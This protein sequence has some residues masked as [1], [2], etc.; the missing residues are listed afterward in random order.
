MA[1]FG[2]I[3]ARTLATDVTTD[4]ADGLIVTTTG[5]FTDVSTNDYIE[6]GDILEL[7]GEPWIVRRVESATQLVLYPNAAGDAPTVATTFAVGSDDAQRRT[8][9]KAVADAVLAPIDSRVERQ[10]LYISLA[11][12]QIEDNRSRGLKIPGWHVFETYVN[13]QGDTINRAECIAAVKNNQGTAEGDLDIAG[14]IASDVEQNIVLLQTWNTI[15]APVAADANDTIIYDLFTENT[16]I[17][18]DANALVNTGDPDYVNTGSL[19]FQWQRQKTSNGRWANVTDTTD[20][21]GIFQNMLA[22]A[23]VLDIVA[24]AD[25][26]LDG[27]EFRV[28][29][30]NDEGATE[31][32]SVDLKLSVIDT[33]P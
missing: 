16:N 27:Y 30:T 3:D 9:P 19:T 5:D 13:G 26:S 31:V 15:G 21:G 20:G 2:K 24:P 12:A 17:L 4:A 32:V 28:K 23:P 18:V 22:G 10:I 29:V 1:V 14:G 6:G 7:G 8:A 25:T 33:T 11:E